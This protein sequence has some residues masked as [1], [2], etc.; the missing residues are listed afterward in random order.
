MTHTALKIGMD[1]RQLL[2]WACSKTPTSSDYEQVT[3]FV[4]SSRLLSPIVGQISS[5]RPGSLVLDD[6]LLCLLQ[7]YSRPT[8]RIMPIQQDCSLAL[9]KDDEKLYIEPDKSVSYVYPL[10]IS[11][12]HWILGIVSQ[13]LTLLYYPLG[14][15]AAQRGT[16]CIEYLTTQGT[17][18]FGTYNVCQFYG[19]PRQPDN[20]SC[21]LYVVYYFEQ[22]VSTRRTQVV[23]QPKID[24]LAIQLMKQIID[25]SISSQSVD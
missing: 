19:L 13:H 17:K 7:C 12:S 1:V 21:G 22:F 15:Q 16:A 11:M 18:L 23:L 10:N 24:L 8:Y 2:D 20:T 3:Q 5:L 25:T 9:E 14:I 4:K 6:A